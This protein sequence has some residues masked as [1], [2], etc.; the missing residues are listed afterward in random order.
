MLLAF[1]RPA[2]PR[3][4]RLAWRPASRTSALFPVRAAQEHSLAAIAGW[5]EDV[6]GQSGRAGGWRWTGSWS[7]AVVSDGSETGYGPAAARRNEDGVHLGRPRVERRRQVRDH[8]AAEMLDVGGDLAARSAGY[9]RRGPLG[10]GPTAFQPA[11][12]GSSEQVEGVIGRHE[13]G[14]TQGDA[15]LEQLAQL[16]LGEHRDGLAVHDVVGAVDPSDA[17]LLGIDRADAAKIWSGT[18]RSRAMSARYSLALME[19]SPGWRWSATIAQA[20]RSSIMHW[21]G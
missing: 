2:V 15:G 18:P 1:A 9:P 19:P 8:R 7:R 6:R 5:K 4:R 3:V 11:V 16:R 14:V 17:V 21:S 12:D 20:S 13:S 10:R